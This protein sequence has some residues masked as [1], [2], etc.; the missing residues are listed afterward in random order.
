MLPNNSIGGCIAFRPNIRDH[1]ALDSVIHGLGDIRRVVTDPLQILGD[2]QQMRTR[3]DVARIF[4]HVSNELAK[5]RVVDIVHHPVRPPDLD[6][7]GRV[8]VAQ[9]IDDRFQLLL[10]QRRHVGQS[11]KRI[12]QI[13]LPQND[14]ALGD[15]GG[16]V[17]NPLQI[18]GDLQGRHD[19]PEITRHRL[20]QRQHA[21]HELL[22][23]AFQGIDL[24]VFFHHPHRHDTVAIEDRLRR[25]GDLAFHDPAHVGQ[26]VAQPLQITIEALD[27]VFGR[28]R[29]RYDP[30]LLSRTG[31]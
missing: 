10:H 28:I 7:L 22:D 27:Q 12:G 21:Y 17:A 29:H 11:G 15:I 23:L 2:E 30:S 9:R 18:S 24:G 6:R 19:P 20:A 8:V 25:H 5:Q 4:H 3:R 13:I 14:A 26:H 1:L 31:R 16:I